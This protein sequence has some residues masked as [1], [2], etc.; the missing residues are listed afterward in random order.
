MY[1]KYLLILILSIITPLGLW[2]QNASI[3]VFRYFASDSKNSDQFSFL[4]YTVSDIIHQE[5][6]NE[7]LLFVFEKSQL[8]SEAEASN[9]NEEDFENDDKRL[10]ICRNL[11]CDYF[12]WGYYMVEQDRLIL[13]NY[14]VETSSGRTLKIEKKEFSTGPE[15]FDE[16]ELFTKSFSRWINRELPERE[17]VREVIIKKET[18]YVEKDDPVS[19]EIGLGIFYNFILSEYFSNALKHGIGGALD[20]NIYLEAATP[21]YFGLSIPVTMLKTKDV[22]LMD[23]DVLMAP[24]LARV[25]LNL[26]PLDFLHLQFAV[27]GGGS[28]LF[29]Y[30]DDEILSY[31]RPA[32]G[33]EF[34][35]V[36]IPLRL[37]KKETDNRDL[38][39]IKLGVSYLFVNN[40]YNG[41]SIHLIQPQLG[42]SFSL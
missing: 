41:N 6:L 19:I 28:F 36:F 1:K 13:F 7:N 37:L 39:F 32:L 4:S 35:M 30:K 18:V 25:G 38:L 21:F 23:I 29:G 2:S 8:N 34:H 16:V 33:L 40:T 42:L 22:D 31:F 11:G 9:W 24:L 20:I 15:I 12:I 14:L 26:K 10:K 3:A 5:L 17:I 27:N